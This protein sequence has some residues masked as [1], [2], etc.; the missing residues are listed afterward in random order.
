MSF[1]MTAPETEPFLRT[2][3]PEGS[4]L[5]V[6]P[7]GGL[8][9]IGMNCLALEEARGILVVDCGI[10][11]PNEDLGVD[12]YHPDLSYLSARSARVA[13]VFLTHG[14]EDH[15]GALPYLLSAIKVPVWG[16]PHALAV[17]KH[18]L[19]E[20]GMDPGRFEFITVAPRIVYRVGPFEVEPIRVTHSI[21]DATALAIRTGAGTVVHT[22][23]FRFDP[24]PIDGELTDEARLAELGQGG[25]RLLLSDSTNVDA[26]SLHV[27]ETEVGETLDAL[28]RAADQRVVIGLFASNIQRLRT[29]GNVALGTGRKIALLGRSIELQVQWAHDIGRL[30]W[31]SDLMIA[32]DQAA[33]TA[34]D[35]LLVLAGGTQAEA[36]SSMVRLA[37]RSHPALTLDRGD[38]VILSSRVIPGNDRPV[39][40]MIA[41][42]LRQGVTVKSWITDPSVHTSGH[43]HR[44]EQRK[45]IDLVRP[46]AFLPVHG[47]RHHLERHAELAREAGVG[48][49]VVIE[50]GEVVTV[51]GER[52]RIAGRVPVGRIAT[53]EGTAISEA[54]LRDRRLLARGGALS[55]G[56]A[57][58]SKGRLATRPSIMARGVVLGQD[59][60]STLRAVALE[61]A[62]SLEE[63]P[64]ARDDDAIAEI[65][66]LAAR[67]AVEARTGRKPVCLVTVV[68]V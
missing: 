48:E 27:S 24:A 50:N 59:E 37:N 33:G 32:K 44:D 1:A 43:A 55:I 14:H 36:G 41:D 67:R 42:Y 8:G 46:R 39:F 9:E 5:R 61:I 28:V 65:A 62:K 29:I 11:F 53:W 49:V 52:T 47:T 64:G 7:L 56:L 38:T 30:A 23:D 54:V 18:R 16:P 68:R 22:G 4:D 58:D 31:P 51:D 66:R 35:R 40:A 57:L 20:R 19:V 10:T 26:R 3:P 63:A 25:V 15:V 34:R 45:M 13:G 2:D 12:T 17:A 21:T 60:S 6:V